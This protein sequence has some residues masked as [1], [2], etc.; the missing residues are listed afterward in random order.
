[1]GFE[2]WEQLDYD[3]PDVILYPAGGGTGIVALW[4]AFQELAK[5][6]LCDAA[7]LPRLVAV[8]AEG[9]A[10][11]VRAFREKRMTAE[12]W[13][14]TETMAL[15]IRVPAPLGD[16]LALRALYES[17]GY[18]VAVSDYEIRS[19]IREISARTGIFASPEGAAAF[20]ALAH[21]QKMNKIPSSASVVLFNTGYGGRYVELL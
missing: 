19:G 16:F 17:D 9:C 8:Q 6:A 21:L 20:A 14:K 18:A 10:P 2:L 4:K 15:G 3:L 5:A 1:M 12:R 11:L 7:R 13:E